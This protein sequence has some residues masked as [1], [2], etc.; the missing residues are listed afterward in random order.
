MLDFFFK[1]LLSNNLCTQF[2]A[3]R[4]W[5]LFSNNFII[6]DNDS[7]PGVSLCFGSVIVVALIV[8]FITILLFF[9]DLHSAPRK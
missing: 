3:S 6:F 8:N 4:L 7:S 5:L 1:C 2:L 9:N